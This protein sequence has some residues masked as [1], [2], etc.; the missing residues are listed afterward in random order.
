MLK[1]V[2]A[3][4]YTVDEVLNLATT[5]RR[6][7]AVFEG[8]RVRLDSLRY[9]VFKQSLSCAR[10]GLEGEFF[11]LQHAADGGPEDR[12]HFNLYGRLPDGELVLMTKDHTH[13]K[14]KGGRDHVSNLRTMCFP[15]NFQKADST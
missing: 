14:S 11:L 2:G 7:E 5:E 4:E 15:C 9:Q 3:R 1:T 10:C 6:A 12:A 13:P 8:Y